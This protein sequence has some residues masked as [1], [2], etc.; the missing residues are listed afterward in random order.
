MDPY[1]LPRTVVPS[2]YD[3]RLEYYEAGGGAT[4][5]Q[6]GKSGSGFVVRDWTGAGGGL[7]IITAYHVVQGADSLFLELH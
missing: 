6:Q 4:A 2:R 1:R 3:I 7:L 5:C